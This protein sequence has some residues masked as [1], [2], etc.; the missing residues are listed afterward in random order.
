MDGGPRTMNDNVIL[1]AHG[2]G[3]K[4]SA[5]LIRG[6]FLKHFANPTLNALGDS[7][8]IEGGDRLAFTTDSFVVDP[9]FFPG[10]DIG[11]LAVCGT[12]ND[13]ASAGA[14]PIALSA[15]F[16]LEEGLGFEDLERI[17]ASMKQASEEA[18]VQIVT[19]DTKVVA[20]GSAD[21]VF[22]TTSGIG[23]IP[24]GMEPPAPNRASPGDAVILSGTIADHGMA[25]M[26]QREGI[27]FA[28]EITSDCAPLYGLVACVLEASPNVHCL[29]DPTRGGL[30]ATLNELAAQSAVCIEVG[31]SEIP[32]NEDVRV[33]CE[34]LGIDP[35]HV[36][37]E[38]KM[39]AIVPAR[40]AEAVLAAMRN[41]PYGSRAQIIGE[42]RESPAGRVHLRTAMGS[43]RILDTPS[44]DILPRIC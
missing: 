34:L 27:R 9:I 16:I 7:A 24:D 5:D 19:G 15:A 37:N 2:A 17:V 30:A 32:V 11:K 23:S 3:G 33:A 14:K 41:H 20:R 42:V 4:K 36:A 29:R 35:L 28:S 31:E 6:L 18:E 8:L 25:V 40:E 10:G 44:G 1:L 22:I 26:A 21:R 12:V 43:L 38:G 39:V 13:L